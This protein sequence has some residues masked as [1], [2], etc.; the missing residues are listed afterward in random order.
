MPELPE[1]EAVCRKLRREAAGKRVVRMR[2]VRPN[3]IAPQEPS[4]VEEELA[5][6]PI[7]SID[8]RG[9]NIFLRFPPDLALH[10]H[11]RMT[12]NLYAAPDVRFRPA[13]T[14]V[15][16]ELEGG[17]G[18]LFDDP[19]NLGRMRLYRGEELDAVLRKIG[20]EPL[21]AEFTP[22]RLHESARASRLP[23]KL[24][25]MDQR[26]IA[27]LGNIYAA[28]ALFRAGVHPQRVISTLRR[29]KIETLH[30]AIVDILKLAVDSAVLAYSMPGGFDEGESFPCAVYDREGEPCERCRRKIKRIAQGG[31]ST[32]FCPGCQR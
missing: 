22:A 27:G 12:G 5:G 8:R 1:V 25:L 2:F 14:R 28:E 6:R 29:P 4:S 32:Y 18:L 20:V 3:V 26:H 31:R 23:A 9:K 7:E 30:G 24:F 17:R 10:V 11:L 16:F 13:A 15:W 21:S 19:R